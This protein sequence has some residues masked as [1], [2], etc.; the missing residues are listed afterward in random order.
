VTSVK[1]R[2][3]DASGNLVFEYAGEVVAR[4]RVSL[5]LRARWERPALDLGYV[6]FE[7]GDAFTEW[8]YSYRWYNV[9]EVRAAATG[10]LKGWYCNVTTPA[11]LQPETVESRDLLLDMWV[12]PQGAC[13]VLDEDEFAAHAGLDALTRARAVHGLTAI[14][15]AVARHEGPF[16]AL[17]AQ[18]NS[19]GERT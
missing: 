8:F 19:D 7:P 12:T 17:R 1:V 6:T 15:R 4:T 3:L 16:R 10:D 2:K 13:L 18:R 11:C 14:R 5:C 9:F